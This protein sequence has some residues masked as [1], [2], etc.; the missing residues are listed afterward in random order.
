MKIIRMICGKTLRYGINNK[1]IRDV[2][3][4]EK[5]EEFLSGQ[6]LQWFGH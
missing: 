5:I 3:G 1:T 4:V 2:T 6:K